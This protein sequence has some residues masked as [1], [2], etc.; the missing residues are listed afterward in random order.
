MIKKYTIL[1]GETK[2]YQA[3]YKTVDELI[4]EEAPV[5]ANGVPHLNGGLA[6][7]VWGDNPVGVI[8]TCSNCGQK[9]GVYWEKKYPVP[10]QW[11]NYTVTIKKG[12]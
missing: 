3:R 12:N 9:M 2:Y 8:D 5:D 10:N 6:E 1:L 4:I 11:V 7:N